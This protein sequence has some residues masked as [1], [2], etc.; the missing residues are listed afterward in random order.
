MGIPFV[1]RDVYGTAGAADEL[2]ARQVARLPAFIVADRLIVGFDRQAL[3]EA[4]A[5]MPE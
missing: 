4:L 3:L 1:V 2:R 5:V